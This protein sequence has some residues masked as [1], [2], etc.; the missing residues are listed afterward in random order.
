MPVIA[1]G[2]IFLFGQLFWIPFTKLIIAMIK[3]GMKTNSIKNA[4]KSITNINIH[5]ANKKKTNPM[6]IIYILYDLIATIL[7]RK[8]HHFEELM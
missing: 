8:L 2:I 6:L 3:H 7:E 5:P 1:K 4:I